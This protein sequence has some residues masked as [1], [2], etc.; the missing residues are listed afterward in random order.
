LIWYDPTLVK[1]GVCLHV[2]SG[3]T[4]VSL[5]QQQQ[6]HLEEIRKKLM[7]SLSESSSHR[8]IRI[9][10]SRST[11]GLSLY[12]SSITIHNNDIYRRRSRFSSRVFNPCPK[13]SAFAR[14]SR[15]RV[16]SYLRLLFGDWVYFLTEDNYSKH[17]PENSRH[18]LTEDC[19]F[20]CSW[21]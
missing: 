10:A 12:T 8:D 7:L 4:G 9:V 13:S 6:Q 5:Q 15:T 20:G 14:R 2:R 18:Y 1:T 11:L 19:V 3:N 16:L 21:I 17:F